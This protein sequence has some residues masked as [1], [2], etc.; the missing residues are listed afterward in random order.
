VD[1]P[2]IFQTDDFPD[3]INRFNLQDGL[4]CLNSE[5]NGG[6]CHDYQ[7]RYQ[8]DGHWMAWQDNDDP[9]YS[10]DWETRNGFKNLC[11][12]PTGIQARYKIGKVYHY[13]NGPRDRLYQYDKNGLVCLNQDQS[14]GQCHDYSVRFICP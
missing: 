4:V 14:N 5:Q 7:V 13:A 11:A 2:E 1:D 6:T 10:G 9:G 12:S 8:C 3:V